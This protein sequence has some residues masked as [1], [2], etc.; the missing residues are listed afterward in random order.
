M[1]PWKVVYNHS[2]GPCHLVPPIGKVH[3][4][5]ETAF[6]RKSTIQCLVSRIGFKFNFPH[7]EAY[8]SPH[9][10]R[11]RA[12]RGP[13]QP[14]PLCDTR[15]IAVIVGTVLLIAC[16]GIIIWVAIPDS[17]EKIMNQQEI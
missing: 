3:E 11:G 15:I 8:S 2:P 1:Q 6:K 10:H 4:K 7:L 5:V 14:N 13:S 9:G 17:S 16:I 12:P